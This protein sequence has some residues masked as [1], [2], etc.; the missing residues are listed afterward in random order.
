MGGGWF[1]LGK[2]WIAGVGPGCCCLHWLQV[3]KLGVRRSYSE[4]AL[5]EERHTMEQR[6]HLIVRVRPRSYDPL[7]GNQIG[8]RIAGRS[9]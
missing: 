1:G 7:L 3:L 4:G 9:V 8:V 2:G 5:V 6:M